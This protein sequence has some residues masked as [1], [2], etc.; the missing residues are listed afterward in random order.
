[1]HI[2]YF[3]SSVVRNSKQLPHLKQTYTITT[4][5]ITLTYSDIVF[6]GTELRSIVRKVLKV[7]QLF[8]LEIK[9]TEMLYITFLVN[10]HIFGAIETNF[11][12]HL[13]PI[14]IR[15]PFSQRQSNDSI[16]L[17]QQYVK[18]LQTRS[19]AYVNVDIAVAGRSSL[20]QYHFK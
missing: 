1:M 13:A 17:L 7:Y 3:T 16:Y 19:V 8:R 4:R 11:L 9:P 12:L 15:N 10:L 20:F 18:N 2:L 5:K 6:T 14:A